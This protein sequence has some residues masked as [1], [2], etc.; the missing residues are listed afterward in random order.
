MSRT[1]CALSGPVPA[2]PGTA[3][4]HA[5]GSI[6]MKKPL[7]TNAMAVSQDRAKRIFASFFFQDEAV[8]KT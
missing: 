6:S 4:Y 7:M 5:A 2:T 1:K 3:A 8:P